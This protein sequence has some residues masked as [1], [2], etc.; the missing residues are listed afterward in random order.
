N[1]NHYAEGENH[2]NLLPPYDYRRLVGHYFNNI[3]F[4]GISPAI[5][6][7]HYSYLFNVLHF[8]QRYGGFSGGYDDRLNDPII[9]RQG[10][11]FT[12][13]SIIQNTSS[14]SWPL[15]CN[16]GVA[17]SYHLYTF[18]SNNPNDKQYLPG[19]YFEGTRNHLCPS[20]ADGNSLAPGQTFGMV[21]FCP[22]PT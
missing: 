16:N 14:Q 21:H 9:M 17:L 13:D 19:V 2:G 7:N 20:A 12:F 5:P 1:A 6:N 3:R 22:I 10:H 8:G 15:F 11:T 18:N 4:V